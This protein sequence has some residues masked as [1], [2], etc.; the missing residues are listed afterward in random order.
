LS[1]SC[2]FCFGFEFFL[3]LL[4]HFGLVYRF[5]AFVDFATFPSSR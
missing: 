3:P 5:C 2:S 1:F 4:Y